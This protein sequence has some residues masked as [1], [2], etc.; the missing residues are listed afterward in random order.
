MQKQFKRGAAHIKQFKRGAAHPLLSESEHGMGTRKHKVSNAPAGRWRKCAAKVQF[1]SATE[2][3]VFFV[4]L[5]VVKLAYPSDHT[6]TPP[7]CHRAI[8][9]VYNRSTGALEEG[10][11]RFKKRA[12]HVE[13]LCLLRCCNWRSLPRRRLGHP[14]PAK[15]PSEAWGGKWRMQCKSKHV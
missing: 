1:A 4:I 10:S 8:G 2:S 14:R 3:T 11:R 12:L 9:I 5:Q 15:N 7:P 13:W 6:A